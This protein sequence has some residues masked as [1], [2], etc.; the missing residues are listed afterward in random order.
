MR[1]LLLLKLSAISS[2]AGSQRKCKAITKFNPGGMKGFTNPDRT[3]QGDV[4]RESV[5]FVRVSGLGVRANKGTFGGHPLRG[6]LCPPP[7]P[8]GLAHQRQ[9]G[10]WPWKVGKTWPGKLLSQAEQTVG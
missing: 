9:S 8:G 1:C 10:W 3:N 2:G 5:P 6:K 7:A 4:G